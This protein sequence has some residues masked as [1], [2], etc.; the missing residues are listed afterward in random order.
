MNR[1]LLGEAGANFD[2]RDIQRRN[3]MH[4][5]TAKLFLNFFSPKWILSLHGPAC[6]SVD[7]WKQINS[8]RCIHTSDF[9]RP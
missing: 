5:A 9:T 4:T 3:K 7:I 1:E 8:S 6:R 2:L